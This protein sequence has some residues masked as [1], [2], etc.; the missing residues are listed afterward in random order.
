MRRK[1][2]SEYDK[3]NKNPYQTPGWMRDSVEAASRDQHR[4]EL[5]QG[6]ADGRVRRINEQRM[7]WLEDAAFEGK[8]MGIFPRNPKEAWGQVVNRKYVPPKSSPEDRKKAIDA[9][10]RKTKNMSDLSGKAGGKPKPR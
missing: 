3:R 4:K 10:K 6:V 2:G 8:Q 7:A 9:I 5:R 1:D